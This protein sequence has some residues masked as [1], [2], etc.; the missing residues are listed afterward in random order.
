MSVLSSSFLVALVA[1]EQSKEDKRY[2]SYTADNRSCNDGGVIAGP[3]GS[4]T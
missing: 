3:R 4:V 1:K 2:G